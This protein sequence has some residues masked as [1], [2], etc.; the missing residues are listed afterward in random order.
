M[1]PDSPSHSHQLVELHAHVGGSVA[2]EIMWSLAHQQGLKLPVKTYWDFVKFMRFEKGKSLDQFHEL[3]HWT[4]LIQTGPL[5]LERAIYETVGSFYRHSNVTTLELRFNPMKRNRGGE[6]DLDQVIAGA[7]RGM[8]RACMDYGTQAGLILMLDTRFPL[9]QNEIVV[10]KAMKFRSRGV[11]GIDIAGPGANRLGFDFGQ[12]AELFSQAK[13]QGLGV[14][15]HAGEEKGS[16]KEISDAIDLLGVTRLGHAI[17]ATGNGQLLNKISDAGVLV[18][19]CPSS[20]LHTSLLSG[21][22]EVKKTVDAFKSHG[23][24]FAICSDDTEMFSTTP[25]NERKIL[26]KQGVLTQR[27]VEA[28]DEWAKQASFIKQQIT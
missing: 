24:K 19:F 5:A 13:K 3:F 10:R 15:V 12:Y 25:L 9:Q 21:M 17:Q 4:E 20:N 28:C 22:D 11:V 16:E 14:T 23:V 6:H 18:E 2:P 1:D 8:D 7:L 27:E 26:V